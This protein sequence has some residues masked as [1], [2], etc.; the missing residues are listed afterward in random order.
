M[1]AILSFI[2]H[3]FFLNKNFFW[4]GAGGGVAGV[5]FLETLLKD[6][7]AVSFCLSVFL[8]FFFFFFFF[9]FCILEFYGV[10]RYSREGHVFLDKL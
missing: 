5:L 7:F 3:R 10:V 1:V 6:L 4:E 9:N 8:F 2:H